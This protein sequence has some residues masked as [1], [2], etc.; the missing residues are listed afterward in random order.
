MI[1]AA[2]F[3]V[4]IY[5]HDSCDSVT[6]C[7]MHATVSFQKMKQLKVL[8]HE[9]N[10]NMLCVVCVLCLQ[11][12]NWIK[13]VGDD[14]LVNNTVMGDSVKTSQEFL[15]LHKELDSEKEVR[16]AITC[17][18]HYNVLICWVL[19]S[20][21]FLGRGM[22]VG[23]GEG[24]TTDKETEEGEGSRIYFNF[25]LLIAVQEERFI[26]VCSLNKL[27][28]PWDIMSPLFRYLNLVFL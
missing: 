7:I 12:Y 13:N 24:R 3:F 16:C 10:I 25:T 15:Y 2:N 8:F 18:Q 20:R 19:I 9:M 5:G 4:V 11:V 22:G 26:P 28:L 21:P 14:F 6:I 17:C 23:L 27:P 1:R